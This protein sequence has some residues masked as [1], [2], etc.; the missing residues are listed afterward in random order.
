ML[1]LILLQKLYYYIL[2]YYIYIYNLLYKKFNLFSVMETKNE[3][4]VYIHFRHLLC[5]DWRK[6]ILYSLFTLDKVL[7]FMDLC[8]LF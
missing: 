3:K 2:F 8:K 1:T 4:W 6:K 5:F 7:L